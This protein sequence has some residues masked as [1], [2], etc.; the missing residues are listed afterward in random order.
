MKRQNHNMHVSQW[1]NYID[2]CESLKAE[3]MLTV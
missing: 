2:E 1:L 3:K